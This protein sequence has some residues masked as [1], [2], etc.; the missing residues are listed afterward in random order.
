MTSVIKKNVSFTWGSAQEESFN[1]I[2]YS[3][4]HAP[5]LTLPNFDK[6]F[7]IEC[8]ASGTCIRAV[9]TQGGRPVAYF[10]EKLSGAALNYPTYDKEFY[11]LVRSLE[12]WQHYSKEFVIHTDHETLKQPDGWSLWRLSLM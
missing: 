4:T 3:L 8:D 1:K 12:S 10:S 7:E 2:K 11:A 9:L 6:T 5:V